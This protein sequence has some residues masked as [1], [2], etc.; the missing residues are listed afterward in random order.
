MTGSDSVW[1]VNWL[2]DL[3]D[4][5]SVIKDSK[6]QVG[7]GGENSEPCVESRI[8]RGCARPFP[9]TDRRRRFCSEDCQREAFA[10]SLRRRQ[11]EHRHKFPDRV[12]ARQTLKNAIVLGKVRRCTRCEACGAVGHTDGHHTDYSRPFYVTWLCRQCHA[13]LDD[14]QHFGCGGHARTVTPPAEVAL[15]KEVAGGAR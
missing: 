8:C 13:G 9:L 11:T 12:H 2:N 6:L 5:D 3:R 14:G 15:L 4:F 10:A 7:E 1:K